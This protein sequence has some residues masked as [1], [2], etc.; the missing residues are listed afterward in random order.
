MHGVHSGTETLHLGI[1]PGSK[2]VSDMFSHDGNIVVELIF[3]F[4]MYI[5]ITD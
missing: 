1:T 4:W 5:A 2:R 3:P